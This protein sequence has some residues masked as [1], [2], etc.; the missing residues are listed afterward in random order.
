MKKRVLILGPT[1]PSIGGIT[2][3]VNTLMESELPKEYDIRLM[4]NSNH[5]P[6]NKKGVIDFHN[7]TSA[8]LILARLIHELYAFRPK[9]V[10]VETAGEIG[11]L[12]QSVYILTARLLRSKVIV[13]LHCANDDEP[14]AE[15]T[16][17]GAVA[18]WYCGM[19]LRRSHIV[20]LLSPKWNRNFAARW[21]L[22]YDQVVGLKNCLG[23]FFPWG[24]AIDNPTRSEE[25]TVVS[26]GSVGE[27]K[28]SFLLIEAVKRLNEV[29]IPV[30]L[31]LVGP[32]ERQGG[33][34]AL[35]DAARIAGIASRVHLLGGQ[36]RERALDILSKADVF[37]L[38]SYAEG[39]PFSIIE[40]LAVGCPVVA[41]DVGAV[42]DIIKNE[43]TGL[44][45]ESGSVDQLFDALCR[46]AKDDG[47]RKKLASQGNVFARN[48]FG[49]H[50]LEN[51]LRVVYEKLN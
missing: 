40:A 32:E 10:Q 29:G 17:Q 5:R 28:G 23:S 24:A 8:I 18:R 36:P 34:V 38:P 49:I 30:S 25:L 35:E 48:E 7:L 2:T 46:L 20:K 6:M 43:E 33:A 44:L 15:F 12:K 42:R 9:I 50:N 1:A 13:S 47:L 19:I 39:M 4:A 31:V 3:A 37:A 41:S 11:F 26:I 22:E 51:T 27:R 14:L 16:R 45:I 21:G